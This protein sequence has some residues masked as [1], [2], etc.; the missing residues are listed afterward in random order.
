MTE[1]AFHLPK[2]EKRSSCG[3]TLK[4]RR[5]YSG[6]VGYQEAKRAAEA[7]LFQHAQVPVVA[8]RLPIIIGKDDYTS[9]SRP[10]QQLIHPVYITGICI[11]KIYPTRQINT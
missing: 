7:I 2:G 1:R 10:A 3:K 11:S 5:E 9:N 4:G 8:V 6:Y